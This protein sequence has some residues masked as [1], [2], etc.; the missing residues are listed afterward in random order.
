MATGPNTPYTTPPLAQFK[1]INQLHA[2][3]PQLVWSSEKEANMFVTGLEGVLEFS[4]VLHAHWTGFLYYMVP[5]NYE[6][7]RMWI[8]TNIMTPALSWN[9]ARAA[10]TAHFQR[11]DYVDG[12][13]CLYSDCRQSS[14]ESIQEYSRRFQTLATQLGYADNDIQ[15][16]QHFITGL[17]A[18]I[19]QKLQDHKL[20]QR[21]IGAAPT[22][23]FT[24]LTTTIGLAILC[25]TNPIIQQHGSGVSSIPLHLRSSA[26]AN[27]VDSTTESVTSHS[28][29]SRKRK[30]ETLQQ[31]QEAAPDD[32]SGVKCYRCQNY[33]HFARS[34]PTKVKRSRRA[35]RVKIEG[36]QPTT[37]KTLI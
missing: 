9:A 8:R 2:M 15:T 31:E 16:I 10:F 11:G 24:S 32:F 17:H 23:D 6:L 14:Q 29:A 1:A 27:P 21:T 30:L 22:W 13:R 35:R 12:Q 28:T 18:D 3:N 20:R 37:A 36:T 7:E 26:L 33:G 5:G 4:P 34:C 19:Q 25:G